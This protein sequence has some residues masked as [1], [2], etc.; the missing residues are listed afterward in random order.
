MIKITRSVQRSTMT[1]PVATTAMV[2]VLLVAVLSAPGAA[3]ASTPAEL[4]KAAQE[5]APWLVSIR[6]ELHKIPELM[7]QVRGPGRSLDCQSGLRI[8]RCPTW[9]PWSTQE[10][11]T[12]ALIRATLDELGVAYKYPFAHTGV[13]AS[14]G[15][16][17]PIVVLRADIGERHALTRHQMGALLTGRR[18]H[19]LT[20]HYYRRQPTQRADDHGPRPH[21]DAL[22][23]EEPEG[24]EYRSTHP[25]RMHACGH[26]SEHPA[27][28]PPGCHRPSPSGQAWLPLRRRMHASSWHT[29][30]PW[31]H[32]QSLAPA[33]LNKT[34]GRPGAAPR[35]RPA[36]QLRAT[37]LLNA[38][39]RLAGHMT[40][41]LGAAKLLKAR[42]KQLKGTVLLVFQPGEEGAAGADMMIK[43][44]G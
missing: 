2:G 31:P 4:L 24:L 17:K 28:P 23:I 3:A 15:S 32:A 39:H 41:L 27:P 10:H 7:L 9:P 14:I 20:L 35:A 29:E 37:V 26:D 11:N 1:L 34:R 33:H 12:S 22:P 5:A 36:L 30:S 8:V 38:A 21:A 16:G 13:V 42:E 43:V 19:G 44:R 40:M 25:G 18:A 6:R